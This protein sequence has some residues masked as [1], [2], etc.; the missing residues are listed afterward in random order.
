MPDDELILRCDC[1]EDHFLVFAYWRV[2]DTEEAYIHVADE[3]RTPKGLWARLRGAVGFFFRAEY[4][5]GDVLLDSV[6]LLRVYHWCE[7]FIEPDD[8][9]VT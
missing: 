2:G 4:C 6:N 1:C 7:Q 3:W 9:R 5:R 8:T